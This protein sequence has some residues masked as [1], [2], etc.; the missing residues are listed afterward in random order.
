[1]FC[2]GVSADLGREAGPGRGNRMNFYEGFFC[3]SSINLHDRKFLEML[4]KLSGYFS[5]F[6][7]RKFVNVVLLYTYFINVL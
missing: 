6:L 5:S 3:T 4:I 2:E 1:M 7:I